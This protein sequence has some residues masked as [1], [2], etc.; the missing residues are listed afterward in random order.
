[1]SK[2]GYLIYFADSEDYLHQS[3]LKFEKDEFG[4]CIYFHITTPCPGFA[5]WFSTYQ[6]ALAYV[7]VLRRGVVVSFTQ[8]LVNYGYT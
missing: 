3:L 6:E 2:E 4:K 7:N 1:M 8:A 5:A